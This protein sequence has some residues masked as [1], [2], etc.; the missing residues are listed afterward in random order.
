[1]FKKVLQSLTKSMSRPEPAKKPAEAPKPAAPAAKP[2]AGPAAKTEV[3]KSDA[4]PADPA[5]PESPLK[6]IAATPAEPAA[7]KAPE[8]PPEELCAITPS[9]TKDQ[10][11]DHLK[12]LY[13]RYNR[14]ASSLKDTTRAEA[15]NMLNAIVA[16]REKHFGL[17]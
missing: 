7:P 13:R 11:R 16:V 9:M 5:K 14:A 15:D 10:I 8:Q 1:M 3:P 17:V 2:T 12:L 6:K 4:K